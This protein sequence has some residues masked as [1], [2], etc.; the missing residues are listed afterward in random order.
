MKDYILRDYQTK[1]VTAI[2]QA[3]QNNSKRITLEM[4]T[5]TGKTFVLAS[6]IEH[7]FDINK[8]FLIVTNTIS[9]KEH[10]RSFL[11]D[12]LSTEIVQAVKDEKI[13]FTIYPR[14]R[15]QQDDLYFG[16]FSY[17]ILKDAE[18]A[19]FLH[20]DSS[21]TE[22]VFVGFLSGKQRI[23]AIAPYINST[24][25]RSFFTDK[26][27][28]YKYTL[29]EAVQQGYIS[30][31]IEPNMY[32]PATVGFCQRLFS[33]LGCTTLE[34][35]SSIKPFSSRIDLVLSLD[36]TKIFVECKSGRY[37][38][39][40][41]QSLNLALS[42]IVKPNTFNPV[43]DICLLII[44]GKV[45]EQQKLDAYTQYGV[46][47]WDIANLLHYVQHDDHLYEDLSKLSYFP[48]SGISAAQPKGWCPNK[49]TNDYSPLYIHGRTKFF[50]LQ[51]KDCEPGNDHSTVYENLCQSILEFLFPNAFY[52]VSSQ[53]KT[54][55][56]HFRM[57]LICSLRGETE[58][59]HPFWKIISQHYNSHFVV[60]EFKNYNKPI[61]Q[62]LI[63][64]TEKYLFNAALRN[65]A[66]IISRHGFS[67][68]ARFAANGC[69]KE[70]SKLIMNISDLDLISMLDSKLN[71]DS[72][73]EILLRRLEDTLMRISK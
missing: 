12:Q 59:T 30:P 37:E 5:G 63:Y 50:K 58:T 31:M 53:H 26:D 60:F 15:K 61:D 72:P 11:I 57:D 62:N 17:V 51:L 13:T 23:D 73:E 8:R 43:K 39:M 65:V 9:E 42:R 16:R 66:I 32:G 55:D 71:G 48:L 41:S 54:E 24:S 67:E 56:E 34:Q 44:I 49:P 22:T 46:C 47:V 25:D 6:L 20:F 18:F 7:L 3:L 52:I 45:T 21:N 64:I 38:Y 35:E 14:L 40:A 68:S 1:A 36:D 4:A 27:C 69:L 28:V 70:N 29:S 19:H 2:T 10:I 33:K